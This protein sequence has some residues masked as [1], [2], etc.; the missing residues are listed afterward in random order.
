MHFEA[1]RD[2]ALLEGRETRP[3]QTGGVGGQVATREGACER[4]ELGGHVFEGLDA[5]FATEAVGAFADAYVLGNIGGK[6]LEPFVLVFDYPGER[7][8]FVPRP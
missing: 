4:F 7:L 1:V 2:L 6:L 5:A 3:G 8:G